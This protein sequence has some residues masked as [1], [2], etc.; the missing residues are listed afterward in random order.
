MRKLFFIVVIT[1]PLLAFGQNPG[2]GKS[3]GIHFKPD[4][5]LGGLDTSITPFLGDY[6]NAAIS[7]EEFKTIYDTRPYLKAFD[8]EGK[9]Y[10]INGFGIVVN[11]MIGNEVIVFKAF[12]N[13]LSKDLRIYLDTLVKSRKRFNIY[14]TEIKVMKPG[15]KEYFLIKKEIILTVMDL[16]GKN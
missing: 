9:V 7:F 15:K 2:S 3:P 12:N 4:P 6:N 16:P 13:V 1:F 11:E 14:F 5:S 8:N 10:N